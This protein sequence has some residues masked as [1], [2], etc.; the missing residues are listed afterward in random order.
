MVSEVEARSG[1]EAARRAAGRRNGAES[2]HFVRA[3]RSEAEKEG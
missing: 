1:E 3:T 2:R